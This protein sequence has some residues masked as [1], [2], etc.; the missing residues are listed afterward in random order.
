MVALVSINAFTRN[1]F[2]SITRSVLLEAS[3]LKI[4]KTVSVSYN[5]AVPCFDNTIDCEQHTYKKCLIFLHLKQVESL[6]G[7]SLRECC[8]FPQ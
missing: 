4:A 3:L 2:K 8:L 5:A 7:Q 1:P 6:A